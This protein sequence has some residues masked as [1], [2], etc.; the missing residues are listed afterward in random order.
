[1]MDNSS[2]S[3]VNDFL[4]HVV[5]KSKSNS[6]VPGDRLNAYYIHDFCTNILRICKL[7]PLWSN[8]M[9]QFFNSPYST[10][11]SASVE[12]NFSELK[13]NILKHNSKPLQADRF[14]ITHLMSLES[15]IK[16]AKNNQL[17]IDNSINITSS[18]LEIKQNLIIDHEIETPIHFGTDIS[19]INQTLLEAENPK[20]L[21]TKISSQT[22]FVEELN[23][24]PV[25]SSISIGYNSSSLSSDSCDD[26]LKEE[27]WKGLKNIPTGSLQGNKNKNKRHFKYTNPCPTLT[28]F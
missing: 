6:L 25:R 1:M 5:E 4:Q 19:S 17:S 22:A 9:R 26:L 13:N 21:N 16:L 3:N 15:S 7:F 8:V 28:E 20:K 27:T 18:P 14:V 24:S 10:A 12:S 23:S 11:T 2:Y